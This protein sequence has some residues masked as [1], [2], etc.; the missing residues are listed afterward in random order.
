V[1]LSTHK[2][3]HLALAMW[4]NAQRT[5]FRN[6]QYKA[7]TGEKKP[8]IMSQQQLERLAS[9]GFRFAS[10]KIDFDERIAML[11]DFKRIHGHTRVPV[12]H[13]EY[14]GLG[15][16][17]AFVKHQHTKK[18]ALLP[19]QVEKL[20]AVG[21]EW[22]LT[23]GRP[24]GRL[25]SKGTKKSNSGSNNNNNKSSSSSS[26]KKKSSKKREAGAN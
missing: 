25:N 7:A 6:R 26:G 1:S 17:V 12:E 13:K 16:W 8:A 11:T 19:E 4:C 10:K 24:K 18:N 22:K 14:R 9:I 21:I 5:L 15:T 2:A 23:R 3:T 20:N